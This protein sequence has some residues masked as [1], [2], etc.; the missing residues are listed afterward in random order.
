M[1]Y[2]M[3]D[4][5]YGAGFTQ[6]ADV[7]LTEGLLR[8]ETVMQQVTWEDAPDELWAFTDAQGHHHLYQGRQVQGELDDRAKHKK[9]REVTG[10][11]H[12]A[13]LVLVIDSRR[14]C[15]GH[16]GVY[17][18]DPHWVE[19]THY[20]C[21]QCGQVIEPGHGPWSKLIP[22]SRTAYLDS[23]RITKERADELITA[24]GVRRAEQARTDTARKVSRQLG[25]PPDFGLQ[26]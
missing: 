18:H 17:N 23:E 20:E 10:W 9:H 26:R 8:I 19:E 13:T 14:F 15:D 4:G 3:L 12:Y 22:S 11:T 24:E 5:G 2:P 1:T 21:R 7:A 25:Y 6:T 16:E